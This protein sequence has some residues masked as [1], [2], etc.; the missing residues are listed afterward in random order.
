MYFPANGV[1]GSTSQIL[2]TSI[3]TLANGLG[4]FFNKINANNVAG[5]VQVVSSSTTTATKV[6]QIR[7][8]SRF[9]VQRR[10]A[11]KQGANYAKVVAIP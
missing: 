1:A 4:D 6:T 5:L 11:N 8:D 3:D 2:S 7:I 10:R 9:D